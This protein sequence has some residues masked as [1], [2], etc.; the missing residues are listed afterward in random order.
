VGAVVEACGTWAPSQKRAARGRRCRSGQHEG[1]A[2]G[3]GGTWRRCRSGRIEGAAAEA[4]GTLLPSQKRAARW[5]V[6]TQ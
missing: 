5:V 6:E 4:G 3:A 1:A 2:A